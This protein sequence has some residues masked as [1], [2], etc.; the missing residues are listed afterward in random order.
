[1]KKCSIASPAAGSREG[2]GRREEQGGDRGR[3]ARLALPSRTH[4][5]T[6]CGC[7]CAV[8]CVLFPGLSVRFPLLGGV[9]GFSNFCASRRAFSSSS[10]QTGWRKTRDEGETARG[11][12]TAEMR[13]RRR[14]RRG[15]SCL[16]GRICFNSGACG[17]LKQINQIG[18]NRN[19]TRDGCEPRRCAY[20]CACVSVRVSGLE[21][22]I[23]VSRDAYTF[24]SGA[25][26]AGQFDHHIISTAAPGRRGILLSHTHTIQRDTSGRLHHIR[27]CSQRVEISWHSSTLLCHHSERDTC[28]HH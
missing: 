19:K 16:E 3:H 11:G 17:G 24:G 5:D 15:I 1:V 4:G 27:H 12:E 22:M 28:I 7:V 14:E 2:G 23:R 26:A 8:L 9:L 25:W 21:W 13:E 10:S 6:V 18:R 20:R